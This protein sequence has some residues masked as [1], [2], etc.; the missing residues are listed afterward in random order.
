[1]STPVASKQGAPT[2]PLSFQSQRN[3]RR[4]RLSRSWTTISIGM[5]SAWNLSA[6]SLLNPLRD[7]FDVDDRTGLEISSSSRWLTLGLF[8]VDQGRLADAERMY[9]RALAGKEKALDESIHPPFTPLTAW[10]PL[11]NSAYR[12]V[13]A[14]GMRVD[15]DAFSVPCLVELCTPY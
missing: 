11:Q 13:L 10:R 4:R 2:L 3:V 6:I 8:Y 14:H 1:M 12:R 5:S 7:R 15:R 9:E